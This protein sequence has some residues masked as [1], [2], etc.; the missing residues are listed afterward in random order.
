MVRSVSLQ[1]LTFS[2]AN[3]RRAKNEALS[4]SQLPRL[5]T[6]V[7][8]SLGYGVVHL[9]VTIVNTALDSIGGSLGGGVSELQWVVTAYTI[10]FAAC[11]KSRRRFRPRRSPLCA[12]SGH[13]G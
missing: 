7:A 11:S 8:M 13:F 9:D 10:S 3:A 12:N 4:R 2:S 6:L 5:L 1:S